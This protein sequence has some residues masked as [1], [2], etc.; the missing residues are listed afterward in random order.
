K[1]KL[2]SKL[3]FPD[4]FGPTRTTRPCN[5]T[6][7]CTKFRQFANRTWENRRA[8]ELSDLIEQP[9]WSRV[10]RRFAQKVSCYTQSSTD[11]ASCG[12]VLRGFCRENPLAAASG[13]HQ[14]VAV[15]PRM[16]LLLFRRFGARQ[17][18]ALFVD[19]AVRAEVRFAL[20][21]LSDIPRSHGNPCCV[22]ALA[23][24]APQPGIPRVAPMVFTHVD[25]ALDG[26]RSLCFV[27]SIYLWVQLPRSPLERIDL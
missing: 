6:S 4:A 24:P 14:R 20:E 2:S 11:R 16:L 12:L 1:R 5:A 25:V 27:L 17:Q 3:D 13:S 19:H 18:F 26:I 15:A 9:S 21:G 8:F 23:R 10:T 22:R 7:T